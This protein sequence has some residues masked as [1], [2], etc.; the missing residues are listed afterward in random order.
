MGLLNR[1]IF[2]TGLANIILRGLTLVSKF[3]LLLFIAKYLTPE[4]LG[5]W[6]IMFVTISMS[7]LF[8]GLDFYVFNTREILAVE[9]NRRVLHIRDQAA[10]HASVYLF[11]LPV[12]LVVFFLDIIP[13]KYIGWFYALLVLEHIAQELYRLLITIGRPTMANAVLFIRSGAWIFAAIAIGYFYEDTRSLP[14]FWAAWMG[15]VS[16]SIVL[17]LYS[18][19]HYPWGEIRKNRVNWKWI[20][21]GISICLPLFTATIS[22]MGIQF[23]DRYFIQYYHGDAQVGIYTFYANI[24]NVIHTFILT[25]LIMILYPKIIEAFQKND[26]EQYCALMRR[27]TIGVLV[28]LAILAPIAA[29]LVKPVLVLVGKE[30]YA[31]HSDIFYIMLGTVAFLTVSYLPH[32]ALFVRHRDRAIILS[33]MMALIIAGI[34]NFLLVPKY[35]IR[36]AAFATLGAMAS[37]VIFKL[38][39]AV[40][41]SGQKTGTSEIPD[42]RPV[43]L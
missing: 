41:Y 40:K 20:K 2:K 43:S 1:T 18:L 42:K 23:A 26:Y 33:T 6:G 17:S 31:E 27:M 32:Y 39:L 25:G 7:L 34:G 28:G 9:P 3:V 36:G 14:L 8:M 22:F 37:M 13:W 19:R 5:I 35:E 15:G 38:I 16:V 12:L 4:E 10:F 30:V 11:L 29:I 21:K 24:A